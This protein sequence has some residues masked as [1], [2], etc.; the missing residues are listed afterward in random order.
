MVLLVPFFGMGQ[1][2]HGELSIKYQENKG[3]WPEQVRFRASIGNA[4]VFL[5]DDGLLFD[6]PSP[7]DFFQISA[8]HHGDV[9][10][11][12]EIIHFHAFKIEF[13]G[14]QTP[15]RI[16]GVHPFEDYVNFFIGN[17]PAKWAG[18]VTQYGE[19]IYENIYPGINLRLYSQDR[20]LKYD[21]QV[22]PSANHEDIKLVFKHVD[23]LSL[24][25]G[26]L[27]I[28]TSVTE[29]VDSK[30]VSWIT[31]NG[32]RSYVKSAYQ[33]N[34]D[35]GYY[36]VSFD[37]PDRQLGEAL[38]IDPTLIFSTLTGTQ[39]NNWGAT[40]TY[41]SLGN[42]YT[43]GI[44]LGGT[45]SGTYPTTVGAYETTFSGPNGGLGTDIV[46]TKFNTTGTA[47]VYSTYLGGSLQEI[48]HSL[49][50]NENLELYLL[51]TTSSA[52]YP[53]TTGAHDETFNGG[54]SILGGANT[55][56]IPYTD[57]TDIVI[58]KFNST[59]TN[60]AGST[61]IGGSANDGLN[62]AADFKY[63]YSDECRGEIIVDA[64]DNCYVVSSTLSTNFPTVNPTQ[65]TNG[66]GQDAVAFK[67]NSNLSGLLWS[68]YFGGSGDDA[69]YSCQ[70]DPNTSDLYFTG[71]T[72]STNLPATGLNTSY[73]GGSADG[74]I[75]KLSSNG[76]TLLGCTYIGTSSYDQSYFVQLDQAGF[77]YVVGQS[78]GNY[79]VGPTW[80]Y[81]NPNSGQFIHKLS[82][83]L[84][85][86]EFST[87]FGTGSGDV[88]ISI[89]A[90]LVNQCNHIFVSG[91][92]GV[93]NNLPS[94]IINSSTTTGLPVTNNAYQ[95]TTD[96]SDFY[97]VVFEDSAKSLLFASF[98]GGVNN[99]G[100]GAE[101]V[102]GGT[103]RFDKKGIIYQAVCADCNN[104]STV[105]T[106][107]TTNNAYSTT[108][109]SPGCNLG[110][111]KYDLVTLDAAADIDGPTNV[112]VRDS[113][114]FA[115]ESV[116]GSLFLWDFGDGDTSNL[117]EP[118]HAYDSAGTYITRLVIF[119]SV[120]CIQ[121]DTDFVT[122]TVTPGP[123]AQVNVPGTVCPN[124]AVGLSAAGG[125]SYLWSPSGGLNQ[126]NIPDPT[127]KVETSRTYTVQVIDSCG[128]DTAFVEVT[129]HGNE[130]SA[131]PD[132]SLCAKQ[133][134]Q[135]RAEG[136]TSYQWTPSFYLNNPNIAR[137]TCTPDTTI[138]YNVLITDSF[139]CKRE[140]PVK[141][142]VD[143]FIPV[144]EAWG[145][146]TI[147]QGDRVVLSAK[148]TV[149]YEWF[150]K[151][152]VINPFL[153]STP[154]Y[155]EESTVY[156]VRTFNTCGAAF[157]SVVIKVQPIDLWTLGDTGICEGDTAQLEAFG[158][159]LYYWEGD[160][161]SQPSFN[162][163]P[164]IRPIES[165][166]YTVTGE[167][168]SGCSLVDS[169]FVE[170]FDVP[171]LEITTLEDTITGLSPVLLT[172][173]S[174]GNFAWFSEAY[175]PCDSCDSVVVAPLYK[176][177]YYAQLKTDKGC[178]VR[179][180]ISVASI[181]TIYVPNTFTPD[182]NGFNE[183]FLVRGHNILEFSMD[184]YD[185]WG[186]IVF[187]SKDLHNGWN[188]R[189]FN[190]GEAVQI[191]VYTYVIRYKILPGQDQIQTGAVN[192]L[193]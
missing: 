37:V 107:P 84:Q 140:W 118:Q 176:T 163:A 62:L 12:P 130:T 115:N 158:A 63:N 33:L 110:A 93:T 28:G 32:T 104:G 46:I 20:D 10:Q 91:W 100:G 139:G 185:R 125:E 181:S 162:P 27:K 78:E 184:V 69:G 19:I 55:N 73:Q 105:Q 94:T 129:I 83:D 4:N 57:G 136:G 2:Q 190:T 16:Y 35:E 153:N 39:A 66:G 150:P 133:T 159:L 126:N 127:A 65:A 85:S 116:G 74:Y 138:E 145:D 121:S 95:T 103:S 41:D 5:E 117:F 109:G 75:T 18:G 149:N 68:T 44:V 112:C 40:A 111:I 6:V 58:T 17:D 180:S 120:S 48:P 49:V 173:V 169:M 166:W 54:V 142:F 174:E 123:T 51:G 119:D 89:T 101:H 1:H 79:P 21:F 90:F 22:G 161:F 193:R 7:E 147:C 60:L 124:V 191:G 188:G 108:N 45:G 187:S 92:G 143:G 64:N 179:D 192:L 47:L 67:L 144:V 164:R 13:E 59:G 23:D 43:G 146:T 96:G 38:T 82:S 34:K 86:T 170:V 70:F 168:A 135:L 61:F 102:D 29:I 11:M 3:Q 132:T 56:S 178:I 87:V 137:P 15:T 172:A 113:I 186:H 76:Q 9:E 171:Q 160:F 31:E 175:L 155:P 141:V 189:K 183:E 77:V 114:Q 131:M 52:D 157:D 24:E 97:F 148:G 72:T 167:N 177:W 151:T 182:F 80:V 152:S 98:F 81:S 53:T 122:V 88:D 156:R 36:R 154:A 14:A 134:G 25:D 128:I 50:V 30:P 71:G 26:N 165:G 99:T 42:M 8:A 106:F